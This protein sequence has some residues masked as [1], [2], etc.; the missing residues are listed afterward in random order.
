MLKAMP[1]ITRPE[2]S[3]TNL[4][5]Y[6]LQIAAYQFAGAEV[7]DTPAAEC[8]LAVAGTEWVEQAQGRHEFR[9]YFGERQEGV[10]V[11]LRSQ[12]FREYVGRHII[13]EARGEGGDILLLQRK[14]TA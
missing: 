7:L 8:W 5:F 14:P 2:V 13:L 12:L 4:E 3:S 10:D 1:L 11:D 9:G 6:M